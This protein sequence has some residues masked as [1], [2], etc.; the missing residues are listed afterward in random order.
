M[1][2][3]LTNESPALINRV[4]GADIQKQL[5]HLGIYSGSSLK[6]ENFQQVEYIFS[7]WGMPAL[8]EK[9]IKCHFPALKAVFYAAGS[10]QHFAR[11]FL[12]CGVRVFS[13]WGANAV[14]VAEFCLAQILLANKGFYQSAAMFKQGKRHE[15]RAYTE[16]LPGN[17]GTKIGLVGCG[18]IG[19]LTAQLL[20]P[21]RLEVLAYD[22]Y[23]SD[24]KS[25]QLGVKQCT[26][27]QLFAQC[28]VISNHLPNN[29]HTKGMLGYE[30][31]TQ[32]RPNAVFINTGRGA[33]VNEAGLIRALEE[34]PGRTALLDVTEPEPPLP[35]SP[36]YQLPNVVLTPH[37]AGSTGTEVARMGEF[38]FAEFCALRNGGNIQYE[39]TQNM[40]ATMA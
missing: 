1:N 36:L 23:L 13:A 34:Q 35:G 21:F 17:F 20:K 28:H 12:N 32:M 11:A 26:L 22:P 4:Y 33:Q 14:P 31:F 19:G 3:F 37:I 25:A 27:Q 5:G 7:T 39:I 18:M 29:E 8:N 40:L 10:V 9:D 2:I 38:M 15:A 24:E 6:H 16:S 30:L